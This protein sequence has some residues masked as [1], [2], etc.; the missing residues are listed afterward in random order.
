MEAAI[1]AMTSRD[2][3]STQVWS[4]T[5]PTKTILNILAMQVIHIKTNKKKTETQ[6]IIDIKHHFH[7]QYVKIKYVKN[8]CHVTL[9]HSGPDEETWRRPLRKFSRSSCPKYHGL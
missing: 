3:L 1:L 7:F 8:V 9:H 6:N 2:D 4:E 5:F